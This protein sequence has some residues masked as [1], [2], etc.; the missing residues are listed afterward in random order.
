MRPSSPDPTENST[1]CPSE[2][3]R[4]PSDWIEVWWTNRSSPP[5]SGAMKPK[6]F[7]ALNHLTVPVDLLVSAME[8][9]F[10]KNLEGCQLGLSLS[11][12]ECLR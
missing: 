8:M 3:V 7:C 12:A 9:S 2:R 6:P 4:K 11:V 1:G 5:S 10:Q